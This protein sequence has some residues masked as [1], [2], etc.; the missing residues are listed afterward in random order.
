MKTALQILTAKI[1]YRQPKE[2]RLTQ[3]MILK[4]MEEYADQKL[5]NFISSKQDVIKSVCPSCGGEKDDIA[6]CSYKWHNEK[7]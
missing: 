1:D 5:A 6:K 7:Q 4:A 3:K 2:K